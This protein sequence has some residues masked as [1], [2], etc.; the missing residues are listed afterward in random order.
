MPVRGV[1][2]ALGVL[3]LF[4]F[5]TAGEW[6]ASLGF[7]FVGNGFEEYAPGVSFAGRLDLGILVLFDVVT[8]GE[9]SRAFGVCAGW[10]LGQSWLAVGV[11]VLGIPRRG[12]IRTIWQVGARAGM[13]FPL[14]GMLALYNE[15]GAYAPLGVKGDVQPF[16]TFGLSVRF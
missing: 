6:G 8:F 1:V 4:G 12:E 15:L 14:V 3:V 11:R 2:L 13:S 10:D 9:D 16:F 5:P 7:A